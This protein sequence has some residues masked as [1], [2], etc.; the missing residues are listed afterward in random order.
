M[1]GKPGVNGARKPIMPTPP[2]T[3]N[4]ARVNLGWTAEE[5]NIYPG[6]EPGQFSRPRH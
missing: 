6:E 4:V 5:S 2:A 3:D 1:P